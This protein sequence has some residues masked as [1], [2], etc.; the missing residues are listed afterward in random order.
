[1]NKLKPFIPL[2]KKSVSAVNI[3][4][5]IV[6][7]GFIPAGC[8]QES[9]PI[10][11]IESTTA[12]IT[13]AAVLTAADRDVAAFLN[14]IPVGHESEYGFRSREEFDKV[15][16]SDPLRVHTLDVDRSGT[17]PEVS[18]D[19]RP[20][21][22]WR[23]PL[24]VDGELRA[25]LTV[26]QTEDGLKAVDFGAAGMAQSLD[27]LDVVTSKVGPESRF[28][29]R[30]TDLRRD[31][32]GIS[33]LQNGDRFYPTSTIPGDRDAARPS[34]V[35]ATALTSSVTPSF[36]KSQLIEWTRKQISGGAK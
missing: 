11:S 34:S 35:R 6:V 3:F 23:I 27:S 28:L 1:M 2:L 22:K 5:V 13:T 26:V 15:R 32:L 20:L 25:L 18:N 29:L 36:N 7:G 33:G 19:I 24:T 16:T 30:I 8:A 9:T 4:W 17:T 14:R 12:E 21:N 10:K 31:F